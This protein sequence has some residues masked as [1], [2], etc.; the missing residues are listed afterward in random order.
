MRMAMLT[1]QCAYII[2]FRCVYAT[3]VTVEQ[4]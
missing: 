2:T 4:Q 3:I 1:G